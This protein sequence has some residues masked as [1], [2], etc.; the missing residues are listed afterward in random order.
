MGTRSD[1][2]SW[3]SGAPVVRADVGRPDWC[4]PYRRCGEPRAAASLRSGGTSRPL[5]CLK[6]RCSISWSCYLGCMGT[7]FDR[8]SWGSG[9]P[10]VRADVGR[11]GWCGPH[12]RCCEPRAAA[13]L[14]SG[15]TFGPVALPK[16]PVALS[17]G[18][19]IWGGWGLDLIGQRGGGWRKGGRRRAQKK[20]RRPEPVVPGAPPAGCRA[21]RRCLFGQPGLDAFGGVNQ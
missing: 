17:V 4:G 16:S 5:P 18:A 21:L 12:R 7:R 19:V 20:V 11:P 2:A 10:V 6:P 1:R 3:G 8:A 14:R 15:G 9:A 13:F